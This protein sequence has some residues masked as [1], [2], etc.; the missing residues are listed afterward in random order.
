M[1]TP[2]AD[3]LL[4]SISKEQIAALAKLYD[5]FAYALDPFSSERDEAERVFTQD[6]AT[7][8]DSLPSPKL[9]LQDFRKAIIV[10]CRKHLAS[11][12]KPSSI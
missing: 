11:T 3:A 7:W 4:S 5:R 6:V 9:S 2:P 8:Y 10:R 12:S 1:P